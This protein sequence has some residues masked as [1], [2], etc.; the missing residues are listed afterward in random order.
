MKHAEFGDKMLMENRGN[1]KD[2]FARRLLKQFPNKADILNTSI[3]KM[4]THTDSF[5]CRVMKYCDD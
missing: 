1:V 4:L 5:F 3:R 2:F